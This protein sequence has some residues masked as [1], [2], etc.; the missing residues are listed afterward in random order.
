MRNKRQG[1]AFAG[2]ASEILATAQLA[3][4]LMTYM[5]Q[6][7]NSKEPLPELAA[8]LTFVRYNPH[9]N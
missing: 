8:T 2:K 1:F 4:Q 9:T 3:A 7:V 6:L 5:F